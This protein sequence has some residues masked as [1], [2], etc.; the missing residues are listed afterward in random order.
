V[1]VLFFVA[2][3][4]FVCCWFTVLVSVCGL[5]VLVRCFLLV[6]S[7]FVVLGCF[8]CCVDCLMVVVMLLCALVR[9]VS[10]WVFCFWFVT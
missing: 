2:V 4:L 5:V 3:V 6:N 1:G 9:F 8:A 10:L 7:V